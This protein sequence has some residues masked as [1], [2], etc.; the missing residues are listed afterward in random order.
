MLRRLFGK[1]ET[2]AVAHAAAAT[3]ENLEERKMLATIQLPLIGIKIAKRVDTDGT[4]LN[5]NRITIAFDRTVRLTDAAKIRSFGYA[6]DLLNP[7]AQ[8]KVFVGM[9][10][11]RDQTDG[12]VLTI[13]TDRLI[14]KGSRLFIDPGA[15]TDTRGNDVVQTVTFTKGQNKPRYTMSNRQWRPTDL[16]YFTNDVFT[17]APSTT[18]ASTAPNATTVR[19]NLVAFMNQKVS[20]GI[21]TQAQAT[22]A[23]AGYDDAGNAAKIPSANLRAA[24]F[25]LVGTVGE[26]AIN[27]YLGNAN[28]KGAPYAFIDFTSSISGS[29]PVGE[30]KLNVAGT[31]L[32]LLLRPT[33]AGED[34][35]ALSAV[36]AHE[37]I[38]QDTTGDSQGVTPSSQEEEIIANAI[39]VT[40]YTQQALVDGSF[41]GNGTRLV[42]KINEQVLA[43]LNSGDTLFP[44]GGVKQAPAL[45]NNGN[46]FVGAKT[47]PGG[48]GNNT[49]VKSFEDW[50]R[51]EYVSR[52]FNAGGTNSNPT[53]VAILKNIVGNSGNFNTFGTGVI[54]FLDNR[55]A[56]LTDV[57]YIRMAQLLKLTF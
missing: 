4:A 45:T 34:F 41:V 52:G 49:T 18:T 56:V 9:T 35:R 14:R 11:T 10:I 22:A 29:A 24:L 13:I 19:N 5:S 50:L 3:V 7:G 1:S 32:Q 16:S 17:S 21:I 51:R 46:V 54:E 33:F 47:D 40:V 12:R 57:S 31:R 36:L 37:I 2:P 6:E 27:S 23:I 42:N 28:V 30:T 38:H 48:F 8:R 39:Q 25:S 26:P 44:Y 15:L 53:G 20:R 55:N 43:M